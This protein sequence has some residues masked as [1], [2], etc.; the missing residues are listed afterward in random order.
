MQGGVVEEVVAENVL[1]TSALIN[2]LAL[3]TRTQMHERVKTFELN[4]AKASKCIIFLNVPK[5]VL[6]EGSNW[7]DLAIFLNAV[8]H[9]AKTILLGETISR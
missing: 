7:D 3:L 2:F 1:F 8:D 6:S 9:V 4:E 5:V